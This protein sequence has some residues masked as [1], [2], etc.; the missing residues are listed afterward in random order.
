MQLVFHIKYHTLWGER[1]FMAGSCTELGDND[2]NNALEMVCHEPGEWRREVSLPD[3]MKEI[4]YTYLVKNDKGVRKREE[5]GFKHHIS[6]GQL[7][8]INFPTNDEAPE[9][10]DEYQNHIYF[11]YDE[12]DATPTDKIF[13]ASAF[14]KNIFARPAK[15]PSKAQNN[16]IFRVGAPQIKPAQVVALTGNQR[17]L[18]NW[19]PHKALHLSDANYPLWEIRLDANDISFPLEYKFVVLESDTNRLCYWEEGDNRVMHQLQQMDQ[20][21]INS[22]HSSL[23]GSVMLNTCRFR[24]PDIGW[25]ACGTVIPVFSLRSEQSFGIGDIGDL[26]KFIDWAKVTGQHV[27]QVLPMNDTTRTHTWNDSYPYSAISIYAL[28]PLYIHI[29]SMGALRDGK[30]SAYYQKMQQQLN[31]K[32]TV[33]YPSV[34]KYKTAYYRDFFEQE[35]EAIL[36]DDEF[37]KFVAHNKEWLIPYSAFSYLRDVYHTAD[38]TK[39]GDDA[40]YHHE[41]AAR[42]CQPDSASWHAFSYLFFIQYILHKQLK[43]VFRYARENR[44]LLKGDLPIG[45][46]RESVEAWA[47]PGYFN[48]Q[49]Q[50]GAPPDIFSDKGQ[51]WSFPTYNWDVMKKDGFDWWKKRFQNLQQYF[52][53][54]RIDHILG[55]FRIWEIPYD[56][57][58]GLCGYFNPALPL[59]KTEIEQYGMVFDEQW[60]TPHIHVKYLPELFGNTLPPSLRGTKQYGEYLH[61]CDSEHLTLNEN[62]STQRKIEQLF[63]DRNDKNV[64]IIKEGLMRIANEV[65]FIRDSNGY[66]P[67]IMANQS[68]AYRELTEQNRQAFDRL[69]HD[70]FFVR[71][72]RFWKETAISRLQPLLESTQMLVCGEDLGMIPAT[73]H[74][75]MDQLQ[76]LSLEVERMPKVM[77]NEFTDLKRLPY[78]A[79]CMTSTH[80]MNPIRAWWKENKEK[81]QRY[82]NNILCHDGI[83]PEACSAMMAVQIITNHL[84][85]S[86]MLTMIPL[87]DW[88]AMDDKLKRL[89]AG[90]ERIND[91]ANAHHY[92]RYRMHVTIETLLQS[93]GFNEKINAMITESGR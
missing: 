80:D 56:Y 22:R 60:L 76:L 19:E 53:C 57:T 75:V 15:T 47:E 26:K 51:N 2:A 24:T 32:E 71:H 72:N 40:R 45:I 10:V 42:F 82:F 6:F 25:K 87:Q 41:Q 35:K 88:L 20:R 16:V 30:K 17:C 90:A 9:Q 58:E 28:H 48:R 43:D 62:C 34:E 74:E 78:H 33:D 79:V 64:Q 7:G 14:T 52:D 29:P 11:I 36:K 50:A 3:T 46:N 31:S 27:I 92:W 1:L 59:H 49:V 70:F 85:A 77:E 73:V 13:Y 44:I 21:P 89:D 61:Y 18:G 93:T 69:Y 54:I 12:W 84:G 4:S 39:W 86:S 65:L 83:A 37:Q 68:Y 81:T 66:H 63:N 23:C 91:P 67:R 55:F 38:F 8:D 5:S